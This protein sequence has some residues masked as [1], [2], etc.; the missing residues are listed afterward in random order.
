MCKC[1]PQV[2]YHYCSFDTFIKIIKNKSL[3]FSDVM[4]SN[5]SDEIIL[6][7]EHYIEYLNKQNKKPNI[8]IDL[9]YR[10]VKRVL[11]QETC[12]CLCLSEK[13]D[14]L[15][16][17]RG[18]APNGGVCI[19]FNVEALSKWRNEIE[20]LNEPVLEKIIYIGK[21]SKNVK[22]LFDNLNGDFI[23]NGFKKLLKETPKYKN[24]GF[25]E[26]KEWRLF[27]YSFIKQQNQQ[28]LP[29]VKIMNKQISIDFMP[30][31]GN[32]I[33]FYYDIPFELSMISE[34]II[35]P[36][37]NVVEDEIRTIINEADGDIDLEKIK[38]EKT[39]LTFR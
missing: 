28:T 7:F 30:Y 27:F 6:L 11:N 1:G 18:Y 25:E 4:K 2:L 38:I 36:K 22:E 39:K 5:D 34:I 31:G 23:V 21:K 32:Q 10:E 37:M 16:Q 9:F 33:K 3:R 24:K 20:V 29:T 14:L 35:G 19:G 8:A 26:E 17:W 13:G 15:S 12:F